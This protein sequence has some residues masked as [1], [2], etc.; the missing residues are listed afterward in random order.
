ML[1]YRFFRSARWF[2]YRILAEE[3]PSFIH[4]KAPIQR[5]N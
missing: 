5:C 3:K 1:H 2:K 4:L